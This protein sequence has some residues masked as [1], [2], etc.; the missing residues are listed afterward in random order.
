MRNILDCRN[1]SVHTTGDVIK[2]ELNYLSTAP[3]LAVPNAII[4]SAIVD[5]AT[6]PT[7]TRKGGTIARRVTVADDQAHA[8]I[9][10]QEMRN[11]RDEG[12]KLT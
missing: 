9:V 5:F 10:A 8:G 2:L 11:L 4:N 12:R 1:R 7:A 6:P 3:I